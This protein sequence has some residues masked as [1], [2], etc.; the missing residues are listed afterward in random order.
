[1][2]VDFKS[3]QKLLNNIIEYVN[4]DTKQQERSKKVNKLKKKIYENN[5]K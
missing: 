1:M 5:K 2:S 4:W 3:T